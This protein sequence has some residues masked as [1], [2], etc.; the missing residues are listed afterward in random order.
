MHSEVPT[1]TLAQLFCNPPPPAWE[2]C[3]CKPVSAAGHTPLATPLAKCLKHSPCV[4]EPPGPV[5]LFQPP[6]ASVESTLQV[7]G[8]GMTEHDAC[9]CW[10]GSGCHRAVAMR[11][12]TD[13]PL[14][15]TKLLPNPSLPA[16][17]RQSTFLCKQS[18]PSPSIGPK[19]P[20]PLCGPLLPHK[21]ACANNDLLHFDFMAFF[22]L[23]FHE[24]GGLF[25]TIVVSC[26]SLLAGKASQ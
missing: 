18:Y 8:I 1:S 14:S 16:H 20:S 12:G 11:S 17:I 3:V 2:T 25:Q 19:K 26:Q 23:V 6:E 13:T 10:Q 5:F 24:F 9:Q 4:P 21:Q 22:L 15:P 7:H